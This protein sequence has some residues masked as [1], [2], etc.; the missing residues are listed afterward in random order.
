MFQL[1]FMLSAVVALVVVGGAHAIIGGKDAARGQF[2]YFAYLETYKIQKKDHV[3]FESSVI[4][5]K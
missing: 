1:K 2:P 5:I 3:L 4:L